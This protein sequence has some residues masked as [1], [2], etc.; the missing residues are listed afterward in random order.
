MPDHILIVDDEP[1]I[2]R[3]FRRHLERGGYAVRDADGCRTALPLLTAHDIDVV[4]LD[5]N[6]PGISGV[7]CLAKIKERHPY[8]QVIMVTAV[9]DIRTGIDVMKKGVFDYLNKP[10]KRQQLLDVVARAVAKKRS[11]VPF[12]VNQ[13]FLLNSA[14][15]V[16]YHRNFHPEGHLDEDIFGAMFTAVKQ[17]INDSLSFKN[18]LTNIEHGTSKILV[19]EGHGFFLAV[20]GEGDDVAPVKDKMKSTTERIARRYGE[21]I[22]EWRG[23]MQDFKDIEEEFTELIQH[24][25]ISSS[26]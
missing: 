3:M 1:A 25:L 22:A 8:V 9:A 21:I 4:L 11:F 6:M 15:L 17:F 13:A 14:G 10:V 5:I 26:S 12:T 20:V 2:R 7:E 23:D 16:M 18:G 19:E 24:S